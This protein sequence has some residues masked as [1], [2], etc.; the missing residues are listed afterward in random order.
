MIG[1]TIFHPPCTRKSMEIELTLSE[2]PPENNKSKLKLLN[3]LEKI[4]VIYCV[5]CPLKYWLRRNLLTCQFWFEKSF[6]LVI[7]GCNRQ[8]VTT[9]NNQLAKIQ[10]QIFQL[11]SN[12]KAKLHNSS[13]PKRTIQSR[14]LHIFSHKSWTFQTTTKKPT[15]KFYCNEK[16]TLEKFSFVFSLYKKKS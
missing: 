3:L 2:Q 12:K 14:K 15:S 8:G 7:Q 6:L 13:I 11:K 4:F 10:V 9:F 5:L 1:K 16:Y